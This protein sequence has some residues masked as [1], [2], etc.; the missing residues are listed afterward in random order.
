VSRRE[1]AIDPFVRLSRDELAA[2]DAD[3]KDVARFL[4]DASRRF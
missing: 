1:L 3:A 2:L 4:G